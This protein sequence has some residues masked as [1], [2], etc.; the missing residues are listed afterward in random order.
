MKPEKLLEKYF[1]I[2]NEYYYRLLEHSKAVAKKALEIA[3][4]VQNLNP[5]KQFIYEAA[6][7]HDIGVS[8]IIKLREKDP[9]IPYICHG[10]FGRLILEKEG[11]SK[12]ALVS[13]RHIGVGIT[14][15]QIIKE[16]LPLPKR[17]MVP[18]SLEEKIIAY[19]DNFYSKTSDPKKRKK[20][21]KEAEKSLGLFGKYKIKKFRQWKKIFEK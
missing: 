1:A 15:K 11:L 20:T 14:K 19:A 21:F 5:D 13:E 3:D 2:K 18:V 12:H 4:N 17:D 8:E 16:K 7:L 6:M 9:E 10:Y